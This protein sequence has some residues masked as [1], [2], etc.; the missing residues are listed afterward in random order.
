MSVTSAVTYATISLL[1]PINQL[2]GPDERD[3]R[4]APTR[5]SFL[6]GMYDLAWLPQFAAPRR[7]RTEAIV[8]IVPPEGEARRDGRKV[9]RVQK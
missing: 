7:L 8:T 9:W 4:G 3:I 6:L 2:D 5:E 1:V